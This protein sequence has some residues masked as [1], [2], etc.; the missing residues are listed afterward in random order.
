M[1]QLRRIIFSIE[2]YPLLLDVKS[3]LSD[4]SEESAMHCLVC[5][6]ELSERPYW[7]CI[8]CGGM[9][10]LHPIFDRIPC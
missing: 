6:D 5:N 9:S 2:L 3:R 4:S 10:E 7:D 8:E 1:I